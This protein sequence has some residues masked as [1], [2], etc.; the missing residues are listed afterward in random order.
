MLQQIALKHAVSVFEGLQIS[1]HMKYL[2]PF[3]ISLLLTYH[4]WVRSWV[5]FRLEVVNFWSNRTLC[6][7]TVFFVF[8]LRDCPDFTNVLPLVLDE[9]RA[10]V[11]VDRLTEKLTVFDCDIVDHFDLWVV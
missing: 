4:T 8:V 11:S 5:T 3:A 9:K 10:V 7:D 6:L 2:S 1:L